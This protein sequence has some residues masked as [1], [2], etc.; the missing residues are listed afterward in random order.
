MPK[1]QGSKGEAVVVYCEPLITEEMGYHRLS[2]RLS[3]MGFC[4]EGISHLQKSYE[5]PSGLT[6][7]ITNQTHKIFLP[8]C[9]RLIRVEQLCEKALPL[10]GAKIWA[11]RRPS[12]PQHTISCQKKI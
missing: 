8:F 5:N 12:A 11:K 3:K 6:K 9:L 4:Q 7:S 1:I 2:R 10:M